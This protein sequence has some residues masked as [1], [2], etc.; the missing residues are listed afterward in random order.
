MLDIRCIYQEDLGYRVVV[1]RCPRCEHKM[2]G[3]I[4]ILDCDLAVSK[5]FIKDHI[6]C[7][8]R[9]DMV[10][11]VGPVEIRIHPFLTYHHK[12]FNA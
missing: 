3:I 2:F 1:I 7:L 5:S 12:T 4:I 8:S 10:I 9:S 11:S 6:D